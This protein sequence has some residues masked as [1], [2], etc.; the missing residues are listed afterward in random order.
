MDS[1]GLSFHWY[2]FVLGI[3]ILAAVLLV[4]KKA[5]QLGIKE[6]QF[7]QLVPLV[8]VGGVLGARWWHVATDFHLY[9]RNLI[10]AV[11]I[12]RGGLGIIGGVLGGVVALWIFLWLKSGRGVGRST[13]IQS[14]APQ[15]RQWLDLS[16]FGLPFGQA[17][18][19]WGNY[20]NQEI[21][22]LP[23]NVP[24]AIYISPG[25]RLP[26][27]E[28]FSYYHP[29]FAYEASLMLVFGVAVWWWA[30][31][32]EQNSKLKEKWQ[33]GAGKYFLSYL[34]YYSIIRFMLDFLRIEKVMVGGT[35]LGI[36]QLVVLGL[37]LVSG[38][39]LRTGG[40]SFNLNKQARAPGKK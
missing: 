15:L 8:F 22:G 13:T 24:W 17:I 25:N 37:L 27:L 39:S 11:M 20:L 14:I 36:N 31:L 2:G 19:R 12:W 4:E 28:Q 35:G 30:K 26:G 33:I 7:W 40:R 6:K 18:G 1:W 10:Q 29:L 16:V 3:A 5:R 32:V 34:F 9:R 38:F 21:Y 23:T